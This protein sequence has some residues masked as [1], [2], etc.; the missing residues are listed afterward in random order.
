M[1][2][3]LTHGQLVTHSDLRSHLSSISLKLYYSKA[4][5]RVKKKT[6]VQDQSTWKKES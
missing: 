3:V 4:K 6:V 5:A 1:R 2:S